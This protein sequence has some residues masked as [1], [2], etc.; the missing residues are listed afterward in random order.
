M[1][2]EISNANP[3]FFEEVNGKTNLYFT[4]LIFPKT[5]EKTIFLQKIHLSFKE[6][7][8]SNVFLIKDGQKVPLNRM[9][10]EGEEML[11]LNL[12]FENLP[13]VNQLFEDNFFESILKIYFLN[14]KEEE[15]PIAF[16]FA[17]K[18]IVVD[19]NRV[20]LEETK[21]KRCAS[22]T[23]YFSLFFIVGILVLLNVWISQHNDVF[24]QIFPSILANV[25]LTGITL[26]L[27]F[28]LGNL[29][30]LFTNIRSTK[31]FFNTT[32]LYFERD[33][34]NLLK[35]KYFS[36][37]AGAVFLFMII[38]PCWYFFPVTLGFPSDKYHSYIYQ[39][40]EN[41]Y[42]KV[43]S[44]KV[45]WK[46]LDA[47]AITHPLPA[48]TYANKPPEAAKI[49]DIN[50]PL[51][52][53]FIADSTEVEEKK[54]QLDNKV[55]GQLNIAPDLIRRG[56][57][58]YTSLKKI[59]DEKND[60]CACELTKLFE[61]DPG[62]FVIVNDT[63]FD[64]RYNKSLVR[65]PLSDFEM[66][67]AHMEVNDWK[68]P[69]VKSRYEEHYKDKLIDP[70]ILLAFMKSDLNA[71]DKLRTDTSFPYRLDL[72][73]F[74]LEKIGDTGLE[75]G[76]TGEKNISIPYLI[77]DDIKSGIVNAS[78]SQKLMEF[79]LRYQKI[80]GSIDNN[81]PGLIVRLLKYRM[82]EQVDGDAKRQ[83]EMLDSLV[84]IIKEKPEFI[85][86]RIINAILDGSSN[87]GIATGSVKRE[88]YVARI[89]E[90]MRIC[91]NAEKGDAFKLLH[92]FLVENAIDF[93]QLERWYFR[94]FA[95]SG[96]APK[97]YQKD[98]FL[99]Y[100]CK[101]GWYSN[102]GSEASE[103]GTEDNKITW[104]NWMKMK[105]GNPAPW[106]IKIAQDYGD[107]D[108]LQNKCKS[109]LN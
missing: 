74:F 107:P 48:P 30:H 97:P 92:D 69:V 109:Q 49:I 87:W 16:N 71:I 73:T 106:F 82:P 57:F 100:V 103:S 11:R 55:A 27:G 91:D 64:K 54:Y 4:F 105:K 33:T 43:N 38:V 67:S 42:V 81:A 84:Q 66:L 72:Y 23:V 75:T 21:F 46:D 58:T 36:L 102:P 108:A 90:L 80:Y 6:Y 9:R 60:K 59:C 47:L 56:D 45:Y 10:L 85:D 79:S 14:A 17:G 39:K 78:L 98:Y 5:M 18:K 94:D 29:R 70:D 12:L 19:E 96:L 76:P 40:E 83:E 8:N 28:E 63:I 65:I 86:D 101:T 24:N 7:F 26:Y 50:V 25:F 88:E 41:G 104:I 52:R 31:D 77:N 61:G 35:G 37:A 20:A 22:N 2:I 68:L 93:N 51:F 89:I 1:R 15:I 44:P 95:R 34:L 32:E 99:K 62:T 3:P 53:H 13:P